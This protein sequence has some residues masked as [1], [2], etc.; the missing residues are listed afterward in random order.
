[1]DER[2]TLESVAPG[3][4]VYGPNDEPI[5]TVEASDRAG[6]RV[7]NQA[8][9]GA[10]I[11]RVDETGVHLLLGRAAFTTTGPEQAATATATAGGDATDSRVERLTLPVAEE[12]LSVGTRALEIGEARITKRVV[13]EQ[14]MVPVTVRR[15]E[16]EIIRRAPGEP[17]EELDDPTIVEVIRIPLRGEEPVIT[18]QAVVTSEMVIG[19][20]VRAEQRQIADTVRSTEIT[21][22]ERIDADYARLRPDFE[23]HF[24]HRH[25]QEGG[26][27]GG[28]IGARSFRDAE[29]NYRAGLL[30]GHD[31][32]HAGRP[33]EEVEPELRRSAT[34]TQDDPALL[35]R[36]R[37]E[38]RE[39]FARARADRPA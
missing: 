15:E 19:R 37:D 18:T 14:V 24:L 9:P 20:T 33:F 22:T 36:I 30:A 16:I 31:P 13:E 21:V 8:V 29:P 11:T 12:R 39:G 28:A 10:A 4:P 2:R 3:T 27:V 6:I 34:P 1:M 38:V 25:G 7:L 17:R 5:G 26:A 35:E 23:R 32:R